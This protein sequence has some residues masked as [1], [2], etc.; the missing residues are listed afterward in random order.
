MLLVL[1][2]EVK[3]N[4]PRRERL[5]VK[6]S[7]SG[8]GKV[9]AQLRLSGSPYVQRAIPWSKTFSFPNTGGEAKFQVDFDLPQDARWQLVA[10][11][12]G[13]Y[14]GYQV[15]TEEYTAIMSAHAAHEAT[16]ARLAAEDA[17]DAARSAAIIAHRNY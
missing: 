13:R 12:H 17:S 10:E 1:A 9:R 15:T 4:A 2:K 16:R 5:R 8:Y 11:N 6:G 3:F 7:I 14:E